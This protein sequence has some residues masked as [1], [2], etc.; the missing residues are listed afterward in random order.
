MQVKE[1]QDEGF[2]ANP[3]TVGITNCFENKTADKKKDSR[4]TS[5]K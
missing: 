2:E 5:E 1:F 4:M 3:I